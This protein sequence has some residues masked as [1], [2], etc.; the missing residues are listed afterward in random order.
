M[1]RQP[2]KSVLAAAALLLTLGVNSTCAAQTPE[3]AALLADMQR[4]LIPSVAQLSR[5]HIEARSD[6]PG[7][8]RKNWDALVIRQRD[9]SGPRT[10]LALLSP[11]EVKG[12]GI[13][14]AP[15]PRKPTL[16]LWLYTQEERRA[17]EFSP[18]EAD[19]Q[20]LSTRFN[21]EDLALTTRDTTPPVLLGSERAEH[22]LMW[23]VETQPALDRYYSRILTWIA[24]DTRLPVKRE[25]YD[26]ATKLWKV[27]TYKAKQVDNIP[28]VIAIELHDVQSRDIATWRVDALAYYHS[29]LDAK[30]LSPARLGEMQQLNLWSRLVNQSAGQASAKD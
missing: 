18:L 8:G 10:G 3:P 21:F 13:L 2:I 17:V 9:E 23:K 29:K 30:V 6:Q 26:R 7:G 14:T 5:V 12:T 25:Y 27:V 20:F 11:D 19:R 22:G 15:H 28:T 16:G 4:A 24:D 1:F